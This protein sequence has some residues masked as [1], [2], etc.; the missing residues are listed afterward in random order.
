MVL[1]PESGVHLAGRGRVPGGYGAYFPGPPQPLYLRLEHPGIDDPTELRLAALYLDYL[2]A[3][4]KGAG[5]REELERQARYDWLTG[6]GNRRAFARRLEGGLPE[7]WGL[8]LLDLDGLKRVNDT[9][10]HPAG[11]R[12]LVGLARA[13]KEEGLEAYRI[14]GD[15]FAVVLNR[16]DSPRLHHAL[17]GLPASLGVAWA[18]EAQGESLL[19]LADARMYEHK[20]RRKAGG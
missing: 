5:Y 12:L 18:E 10:G 15:E 13:L 9:Q 16:A 20:R 7:G 17:A 3:A 2:L 1:A 6:L 14:G 8:A 11:D 4:L 19:A